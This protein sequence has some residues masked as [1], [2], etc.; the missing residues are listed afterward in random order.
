MGAPLDS[1]PGATGRT[2]WVR[3]SAWIWDFSSTQSTIACAGGS[4]YSPTTSRTS[5]SNSGSVENLNVSI[6]QGLTSCS[7]QTRATVLWLSPSS[8]AS[9]REDQWVTPRCSGGGAS[10]V[11]RIS[12]RRVRRTVW[13]RPRRGRSASWA[14]SPSRA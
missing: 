9:S 12:A 7:A 10:V 2:G 11:A 8:V 6:C 14:V 13:G 5:A 3:S 1:C 4:R